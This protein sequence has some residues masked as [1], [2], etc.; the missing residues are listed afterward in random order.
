[1]TNQLEAGKWYWVTYT[2][3]RTYP[4]GT[5]GTEQE[6]VEEL[7]CEAIIGECGVFDTYQLGQRRVHHTR[8]TLSARKPGF[9]ATLLNL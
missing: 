6:S 4:N 2:W 9:W 1:M 5:H 8:C 3:W 7:R